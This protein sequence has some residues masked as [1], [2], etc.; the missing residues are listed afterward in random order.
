MTSSPAALCARGTANWPGPLEI[1]GGDTHEFL[2]TDFEALSDVGQKSSN[3]YKSAIFSRSWRTK[4][5]KRLYH[6]E[7]FWMILV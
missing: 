3:R 5:A 4:K 6:W 2:G 7:G 1:P